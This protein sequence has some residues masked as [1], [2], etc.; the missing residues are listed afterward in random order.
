VFRIIF[1]NLNKMQPL[2]TITL[3]FLLFSFTS[4]VCEKTQAQDQ[5]DKPVIIYFK[6]GNGPLWNKQELDSF[7]LAR[8]SKRS[9]LI[10]K[11]TAVEQKGDTLIY[12]LNLRLDPNPIDIHGRYLTGQS[13]PDFN[14]KDINGKSINL[15]DLK[16]KPMV[17]NFW[18]AGCV[19]CLA[20]LPE[21]NALKEKYKNS[22][23]VFLSMTFEKKSRVISFLKQ[24]PFSFIP[25]PDVKE[26][27]DHMT[28]LYPLT[29]FVDKN[30]IISSAEHL[31]PPL[32]NYDVSKRIDQL[33]T[34]LFEKNINAI[35]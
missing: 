30:G 13:L 7:L 19:P 1:I 27:C 28:D 10:P 18:F 29:L 26:Y 21:L 2:K 8:T 24:H 15:K 22:D 5:K 34:S 35:K 3:L 9:A 12:K 6:S 17:I 23:V 25:I 33:D 4:F 11:I 20:E 14:F 32:F 16:G 31:M